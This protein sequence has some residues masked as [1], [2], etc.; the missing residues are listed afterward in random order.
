MNLMLMTY[1]NLSV[2]QALMAWH[3]TNLC[4]HWLW[5]IPIPMGATNISSFNAQTAAY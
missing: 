4:F 2:I 3:T 5:F 1:T